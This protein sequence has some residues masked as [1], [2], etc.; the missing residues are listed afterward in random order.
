[1]DTRRF[2][3]ACRLKDGGKPREAYEEFIRV[4]H[5]AHDPLDKAGALLY[6]AASLKAAGDFALAK[7]QLNSIGLILANLPAVDRDTSDDE[8]RV[9]LEIA[10]AF[11][12]ADI[13][14]TEGR[15]EEALTRFE[16]IL[17]RFT[18]QLR[19]PGYQSDYEMTQ[20]RRAFLVAD[21]GRWTEAL[22]L[23]E[24]AE[25]YEQAKESILFYLGYC[26]V[27]V[28]DY[29]RGEEKLRKSLSRGLRPDLEYRAHCALGKAYHKLE[30]YAQAK[31]ELERGVQMADPSYIRQ[32]QLWKWL[33]ITCRHLG[34][35]IEAE[36]YAQLTRPS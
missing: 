21:L 28:G 17:V 23:L 11:E 36:H 30:D 27:A 14:R 29:V 10:I 35:T 4:A 15:T 20:T 7:Q 6:A 5:A 26:Y 25:S 3:E 33:E 12:E 32:A 8:R 31:I 22:P 18:A 9:W 1:M 2:E 13:Y 16:Y 34:L 19:Q 24:Q